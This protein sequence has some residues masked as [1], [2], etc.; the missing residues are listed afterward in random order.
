MK[1]FELPE[2]INYGIDTS[3]LAKVFSQR[4]NSYKFFFF[5]SI[6][7][8]FS[9]RFRGFDKLVIDIDWIARRMAMNAW[10]P[11]VYYGLS[12]G[13]QDSL[14][15]LLL[16]LRDSLTEQGIRFTISP[17]DVL[18]IPPKVATYSGGNL[19]PREGRGPR[20]S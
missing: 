9:H 4:T 20:L 14:G 1:S 10:Y 12:L 19:P 16:S 8:W 17:Q 13:S 18:R 11:A 3:P 5:L 15:K 6:L 7:D 2:G